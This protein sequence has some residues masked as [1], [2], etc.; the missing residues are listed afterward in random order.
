MEKILFTATVQSHIQAF[1]LPFLKWFKERGYETHVACSC[2]SGYESNK[3]NNTASVKIP[4]CDVYHD[5]PF[6]RSPFS[7]QNIKAYFSLKN[8]INQEQFKLIHC[9]TPVAGVATR[10]AARMARKNGTR[11]LY[12]AHG[13]HFYK[14]AP[15]KNWILFYPVEKYLSKH[16]DCLILINDEDYFLAVSRKFSSRFVKKTHGVGV[17]F[18]KFHPTSLQ[19]K[20]SLRKEF[21]YR[22]NDFVLLYA[23]ELS[24]RKNQFALIEIANVLKNKIPNI[25]IL[26]AG[27]GSSNDIYQNLVHEK[28][29]EDTITFLGFRS[30]IDRLLSLADVA[31]SSSKQE[32]LP[33][34]LLEAMASGKPIL[35]TRIRGNSDLVQNG[36]NGFLFNTIEEGAAFIQIL[37]EDLKLCQKFGDASLELVQ[38]YS[39]NN[40]LK[41]YTEIYNSF[42]IRKTPLF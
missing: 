12:T 15:L 20:L 11:V 27:T 8:I 37:Y 22:Q 7:P 35:A 13:F 4:Y 10:L 21:N 17:D 9:H 25:K 31:I 28:G 40:T 23:A 26:L 32:G 42:L 1:H 19:E 2:L 6:V 3:S 41:E 5:I 30:D 29:L 18:T 39:L 14:G 16:T 24:S 34:N 38:P 36:K 33:V